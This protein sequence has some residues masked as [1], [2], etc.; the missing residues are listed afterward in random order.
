M[1][2]CSTPCRRYPTTK[3]R[4]EQGRD[5]PGIH[6]QALSAQ[7]GPAGR[8][9]RMTTRTLPE[10]EAA[11]RECSGCA[12]DGQDLFVPSY[13]GEWAKAGREPRSVRHPADYTGGETLAVVCTQLDLPAKLQRQ[14]VADWCQA[15]P[16]FTGLRTL[17]FHSRLPQGC[18]VRIAIT[19]SWP[20]TC[21]PS[22]PHR[23]RTICADDA[24]SPPVVRR[25]RHRAGPP[26]LRCIGCA[27]RA[28]GRRAL[29][30][31]R[32]IP[33]RDVAVDVHAA[34]RSPVHQACLAPKRS[35]LPAMTT[36]EPQ[37]FRASRSAYAVLYGPFAAIALLWGLTALKTGLFAR[38]RQAG[39][40]RQT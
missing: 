28:G 33:D 4:S 30:D 38:Y 5:E 25:A 1:S 8:G 18:C 23:T 22:R 16:T 13:W 2:N 36:A 29:R 20:G 26:D 37:Q 27:G 7:R 17:W 39:L 6:A 21:S 31:V 35:I 34:A 24:A 3:T 9:A 10:I 19:Q 40:P 14:L 11:L 12:E 15:L 32:G